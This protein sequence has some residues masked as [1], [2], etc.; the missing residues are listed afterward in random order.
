MP[1]LLALLA[2]PDDEFFC[3]GLLAAVAARNVPVHLAWWTRGEGGTSPRRRF[4]YNLLP[5]D[6]HFRAGEARR[7]ARALGASSAIFLGAVDPVPV[8]HQVFAPKE[9]LAVTVGK[10]EALIAQLRPELL[11]THGAGGEYGHAAH[12]R[13]HEAAFQGAGAVPLITFAAAL[14]PGMAS[15]RYVNRDEPADYIL[16]SHPFDRQK[17]AVVREHR[18]Q[19]GVFEGLADPQQPTLERLL[20]VTR[21]E[22]YHVVGGDE[23]AR[24]ETL[25]LLRRWLGDGVPVVS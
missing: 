16:D 6:W 11:L 15:P 3:A 19:A 25:A 23:S 14:P 12:R 13:L 22:G 18:S 9:D 24:S 20:E 10:I 5:R 4:L 8:G 17:T 2:H 21:Y 1:G 7:S